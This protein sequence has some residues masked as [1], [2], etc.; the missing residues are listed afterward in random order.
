MVLPPALISPRHRAGEFRGP[1][2]IL[3]RL[4]TYF[5]LLKFS[6]FIPLAFIYR[7]L[8]LLFIINYYYIFFLIILINI[9]KIIYLNKILK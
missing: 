9:I 3:V 1:V 5:Y 6:F 4:T 7:A 2:V 8:Y